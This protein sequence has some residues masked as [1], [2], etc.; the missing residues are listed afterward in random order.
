MESF[1]NILYKASLRDDPTLLSDYELSEL[2]SMISLNPPPA[3]IIEHFMSLAAE[4]L[5]SN[6]NANEIKSIAIKYGLT[7]KFIAKIKNHWENN[8]VAVMGLK[9]KEAISSENRFSGMDYSLRTKF[10]TKA[11]EFKNQEKYATIKFTFDEAAEQAA[12]EKKRGIILNCKEQNIRKIKK[13]LDSVFKKLEE[14]FAEEGS[15][16]EGEK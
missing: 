11:D 5:E 12:G 8:S 15:E 9:T 10:Y 7:D 14:L 4:I 1:F 3:S 16:S 6:P 13:K 2:E